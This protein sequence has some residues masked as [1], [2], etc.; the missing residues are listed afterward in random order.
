MSVVNLCPKCANAGLE[1]YRVDE[2]SFGYDQ[3]ENRFAGIM[4]SC[5]RCPWEKLVETW[6]LEDLAIASVV[7]EG[8]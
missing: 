5:T 6:E 3:W 4:V 1:A 7:S 8:V 2:P